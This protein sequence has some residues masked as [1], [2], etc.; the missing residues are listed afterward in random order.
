MGTG[1]LWGTIG[2]ASKGVFEHSALDAVSVTWIRTLMASPICILAVWLSG[3]RKLLT[4]SRPDLLGMIGLG[5]ALHR[6]SMVVSGRGRA[7][8]RDGHDAD[9]ALRRAGHRGDSVGGWCCTKS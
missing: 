1:V 9:L 5:I 3:G 6:L 8:R 2:V 4:F 7:N